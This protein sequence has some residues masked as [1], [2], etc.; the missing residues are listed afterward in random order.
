MTSSDPENTYGDFSSSI[1][2]VI[3][4]SPSAFPVMPSDTTEE[5]HSHR[6]WVG[7]HEHTHVV[8]PPV[9]VIKDSVVEEQV[10]T[11]AFGGTEWDHNVDVSRVRLGVRLL[12]VVWL[13]IWTAIIIYKENT[14][15]ATY[16]TPYLL[17]LL[18]FVLSF[19]ND[20]IDVSKNNL[21]VQDSGPH[22]G[23]QLAINIAGGVANVL[24]FFYWFMIERVADD[25]AS[26]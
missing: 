8:D 5:I 11:E 15:I 10:N 14:G 13:S 25:R 3:S 16:F 9:A 6:S 1:T 17:I 19:I 18:H 24:G 23:W 12:S 7:S 20:W 21:T 2:G 26:G 4:D 22:Q